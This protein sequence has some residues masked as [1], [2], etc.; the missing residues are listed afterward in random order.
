MPNIVWSQQ[1]ALYGNGIEEWNCYKYLGYKISISP[2]LRDSR[3]NMSGGC[4]WKT[5]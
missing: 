3:P 1:I 5:V 2:D 4:V